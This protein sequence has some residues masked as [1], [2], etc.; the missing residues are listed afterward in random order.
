MIFKRQIDIQFVRGNF[1]V[2]TISTRA[3]WEL[4]L[5]L[6]RRCFPKLTSIQ[7]SHDLEAD[8]L[9]VEDQS[10]LKICGAY[11][12]FSTDKAKAFESAKDFDLSPILKKPGPKLELAWACIDPAYRDGRVVSLLW[13]GISHYIREKKASVVFG[14]TSLFEKDHALLQDVQNYL[15]EP[16]PS[17]KQS[18]SRRRLL[19]ALLR[20]YI[21]AGAM[22]WAQPFFDEENNCYDFMTVLEVEARAPSIGNHFHL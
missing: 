15:A 14:V 18:P 21:M 1:R 12:V 4:V 22:I 6:R 5:D 9:V 2:Y 17:R 16:L 7:S 8:H 10:N 19:P 13:Q 3:E 11:R 20:A